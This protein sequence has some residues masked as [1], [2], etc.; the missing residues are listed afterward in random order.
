MTVDTILK[1]IGFASKTSNEIPEKDVIA[2]LNRFMISGLMSD[3]APNYLRTNVTME[4]IHADS[5][6]YLPNNTD[7]RHVDNVCS[8]IDALEHPLERYTSREMYS[9]TEHASRGVLGLWDILYDTQRDSDYFR[10]GVV[11]QIL[12]GSLT[13]RSPFVAREEQLRRLSNYWT[14]VVIYEEDGIN[15]L[16]N[17][18]F[19]KCKTHASKYEND[20]YCA[21]DFQRRSLLLRYNGKLLRAFKFKISSF[22][23][24]GSALISNN[25]IFGTK[26]YTNV[27]QD[28]FLEAYVSPH[29]VASASVV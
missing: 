28:L 1:E 15:I 3:L 29:M 24:I 8:S 16:T 18:V 27:N 6:L 7:A 4:A 26:R 10:S 9:V 19:S 17:I 2:H 22:E 13:A 21:I 12:E 25:S 23:S 20:F 11:S 14:K 5:D